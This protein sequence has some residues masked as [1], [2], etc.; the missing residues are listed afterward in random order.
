MGCSRV[1]AGTLYGQDA[2]GGSSTTGG[3]RE[4]VA[5][6]SDTVTRE[7]TGALHV[8]GAD[9]ALAAHRA[10]A[11]AATA[12]DVAGDCLLGIVQALKTT[13]VLSGAHIHLLDRDE[14]EDSLRLCA[15]AGA[16][17]AFVLDAPSL[18]LD[19]DTAAARAVTQGEATWEGDEYG[20]SAGEPESADG[21]ARWRSAVKA[22]ASA[23]L[24]LVVRGRML[25]AL[26]LEWPEPHDFAD[27]ERTEVEAI[28][29]TVALAVDSV[30]ADAKQQHGPDA[31]MPT[32]STGFIV[33][34]DGCVTPA[35]LGGLAG[36][37]AM[38]VSMASSDPAADEG[39]APYHDVFACDGGGLAIVL[40]AV[41]PSPGGAEQLARTARHLLRGWLSRGIGPHDALS[42]LSTWATGDRAGVSWLAATV[43]VVNPTQRFLVSASAGPSLTVFRGADGR[44]TVDV[45]DTPL[46]GGEGAIA[47]NEHTRL[48]LP[49]DRIGLRAADRALPGRVGSDAVL[50]R[51]LDEAQGADAA[52][53]IGLAA[54]EEACCDAAAVLEVLQAVESENAPS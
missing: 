7:E 29:A 42:S 24:P 9:D 20:I 46:L 30:K 32:R 40:G 17:S 12:D 19:T 5:D 22:Q 2:R 51:L 34:A 33:A 26:T 1:S 45:D 15:D 14:A 28:A 6:K 44:V 11:L 49:G 13:L 3:T 16:H 35:V 23:T 47:A 41:G 31:L 39:C 4:P 53:L 10:V 38:R 18:P 8:L 25:G 21:V 52:V 54:A 36:S 43:A 37:A 50:G 27:D 48:L